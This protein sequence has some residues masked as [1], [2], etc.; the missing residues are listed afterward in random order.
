MRAA[1]GDGLLRALE[2]F[3]RWS[4]L[5]LGRQPFQLPQSN[6]RCRHAEGFSL[7]TG[8]P[9]SKGCCGSWSHSGIGTICCCGRLRDKK[10]D[11]IA[12][13]DFETHDGLILV[14]RK[15]DG[16]IAQENE[17]LDSSCE[18][19]KRWWA[20]H[21]LHLHVDVSTGDPA[22]KPIKR[23]PDLFGQSFVL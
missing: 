3:Q 13:P 22:F 16:S 5:L 23:I 12:K 6:T 1:A 4:R 8:V 9:R 11:S 15:A 7:V 21:R 18:N 2:P 10:V 19:Q 14:R 17:R 20:P